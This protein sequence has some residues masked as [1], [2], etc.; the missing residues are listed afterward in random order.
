MNL[1][2]ST[3]G[4]TSTYQP[5]QDGLGNN[6]GT[7]IS[8][9]GILS[10]NLPSLNNLMPDYGGTGFGTATVA[11]AAN[12]QN[13]TLYQ[14]FYDTGFYS[15]SAIT[16]NV[17][18]LT[19]TSDVVDIGFYSLQL[20]PGIGIAP[21]D[22]IMSGVTLISNST[23]LKTTTLPS[24]LSF[25]GNGGGFHIMAITITNGNVTPTVRYTTN[26]GFNSQNQSY[27][28]SLGL[29]LANAGNALNVG[30]KMAGV[31]NNIFVLNNLSTLQSSYS[32]SD[33]INN[34]STTTIN[35]GYGFGLNTIM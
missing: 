2:N 1:E 29:Y 4:I 31:T 11:P 30:H 25:S 28:T 21:K 22:L 14:I 5:L 8:T 12:T 7:R 33:I 23:G 20:V 15:Y 6:T 17:G 16:Y 27:A 10:P 18:T 35:G 32:T 13:R 24:T 19:S 26:N 3:S 34:I 9:Q